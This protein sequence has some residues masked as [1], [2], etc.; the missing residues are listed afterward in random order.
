MDSDTHELQ[1]SL[2][3]Q[4]DW[5]DVLIF[6]SP[7]PLEVGTK[8]YWQASQTVNYVNCYCKAFGR[9]YIDL[10]G[11]LAYSLRFKYDFLEA[12]PHMV[13]AEIQVAI[14]Y[15]IDLFATLLGVCLGKISFD[16]VRLLI[17]E[18]FLYNLNRSRD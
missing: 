4:E 7:T 2:D 11:D 12:E 5:V 1:A 10:H 17:D 6:I 13:I 14:E 3:F 9:F 16:K 18:S 15:Y 8:N